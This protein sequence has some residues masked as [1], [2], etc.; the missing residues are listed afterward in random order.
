MIRRADIQDFA[1][2][3]HLIELL[4][5]QETFDE[6]EFYPLLRRRPRSLQS[7]DESG[8]HLYKLL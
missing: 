7:G 2:V 8:D 4:E 3:F 6:E 1:E 5:E